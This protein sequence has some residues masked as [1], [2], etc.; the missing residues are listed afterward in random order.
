MGS[1]T[2]G[3]AARLEGRRFIGMEIEPAYMQI[4]ERRITNEQP[5]ATGLPLFSAPALA[6]AAD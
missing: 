5:A 4:A 3:V 2:T 1:G 6:A